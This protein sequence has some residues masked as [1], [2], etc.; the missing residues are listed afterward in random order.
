M[1][2][3]FQFFIDPTNHQFQSRTA[4]CTRTMFPKQF[5]KHMAKKAVFV[6]SRMHINHI[7]SARIVAEQLSQLQQ[8]V[9]G[10]FS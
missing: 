5:S 4:Q 7:F 3:C 10:Q 1:V 8:A 2:V 9:I 6:S